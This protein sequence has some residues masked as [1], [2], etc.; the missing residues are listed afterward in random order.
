LRAIRADLD[1]FMRAFGDEVAYREVRAGFVEQVRPLVALGG[2]EVILPAGGLP[3]LL[4]G[5]EHGFAVDG[6]PVLSGIPVAAKAAEM[7]VALHRLTG[8]AV[9]RRGAYAKAPPAAIEEFIGG[10]W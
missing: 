7:A 5:R 3:M 8:A 1:G 4:F 6:A 9:S 2:A 10:R